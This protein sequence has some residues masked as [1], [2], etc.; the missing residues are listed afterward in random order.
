M[1]KSFEVTR[2]DVVKSSMIKLVAFHEDTTFVQFKNDTVYSYS[3]TKKEDYD[4]LIK[5]KSVGVHLNS[6]IKG[7]FEYEK[8]DYELKVKEEKPLSLLEQVNN[9]IKTALK[10]KESL[11]ANVLKLVKSELLNNEKAKKPI[12]ELKVVSGYHK[13]LKK[14]LEFFKGDLATDLENEISIIEEFLPKEMSDGELIKFIDTCFQVHINYEDLTI[15]EI[16]G[17]IKKATGSSNGQLI[18]SEVKKHKDLQG[19]N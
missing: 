17:K 16:I 5:A 10:S 15:G 18:A 19:W 12:S 1:K 4:A 8:V 11:R 13:K 2:I 3:G 6:A 7:N 14:S 9:S